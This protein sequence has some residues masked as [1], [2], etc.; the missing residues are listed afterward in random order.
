MNKQFILG[1]IN[2][3]VSD[4]LYYDRKDDEELPVGAIE[5]CISGEI[6]TI[7]EMV[8]YFEESLKENLLGE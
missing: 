8:D 6:I 2:D 5:E 3:L 7:K 4:F 1:T